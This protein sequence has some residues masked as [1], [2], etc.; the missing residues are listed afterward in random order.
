[1]VYS[2]DQYQNDADHQPY[3]VYGC[4]AG[5]TDTS[6]CQHT[7]VATQTSGNGIYTVRKK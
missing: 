4:T 2:D 1:M 6:T 3:P 7:N 5:D